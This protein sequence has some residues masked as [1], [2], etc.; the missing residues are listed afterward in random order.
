MNE[1]MRI[2]AEKFSRWGIELPAE[3]I[4]SKVP[5]RILKDGWRILFCFGQDARGDYLDYYASHR[6][7]DDQHIRIYADGATLELAALVGGYI[8]SADPAEA[9]RCEQE[10]YDFNEGVL[11][12]L[13]AKGFNLFADTAGGSVEPG[14]PNIIFE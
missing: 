2:F 7:S 1:L 8:S 9:K 6:M 14:L 3:C 4:E 5:G 12:E 13:S 11:R 10:F